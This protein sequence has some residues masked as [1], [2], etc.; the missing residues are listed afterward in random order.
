MGVPSSANEV[1]IVA[2]STHWDPNWLLKAAEYA[3]WLVRPTLDAVLDVLEDEPRRVFSLEC[4]FF[5]DRY[6]RQRPE[7]RQR[8]RELIDSNR[9]HF[10]GSGVTT[11]DTLLVDDE[12]LLRDLL[13]G[14]EWLREHGMDQQP[15]LL[16][17]PDSFGHSPGLPAILQS[18]GIER[19]AICRIA[20]MRFPGADLESASRFPRPG[21]AADELTAAGT[22]DFVWRSADGSEVLAHWTAHG[23]GHGDMI[24]SRGLSRALRLPLSFPDR[25]AVHVDRRIEKYLKDLRKLSL[26]PYRL[27]VLGY[28]FATPVPRLVELL[29]DWNARNHGRSGTFLVNGSIDDYLDLIDCHRGVLPTLELDP[30]PYWSGFYAS[31]TNIKTASRELGRRLIAREACRSQTP[32][33]ADD[34]SAWWTAVTSNHHDFI[35]G[36]S[37]DRVAEGEQMA[38][39][40][41]AL[42]DAPWPVVLRSDGSRRDCDDDSTTR[43]GSPEGD[44]GPGDGRP[45][46]DAGAGGRLEVEY[47]GHRLTVRAPWGSVTFDEQLGGAAV[48]VTDAHGRALA[49]RPSLEVAS[50]RDS[51]G[52]WRLGQEIN[53]GKWQLLDRSSRHPATIGVTTHGDG[54]RAEVRVAARCDE[55]DVVIEHRLCSMD[56]TVVS[57]VSV[58]PR[59]R[60]TFTLLIRSRSTVDSIVMHQPGGLVRRPLQ[61]FYRP[62]FWPL[63]SFVLTDPSGRSTSPG[64]ESE[65]SIVGVATA[66]PTG[67]H[68]G[69]DG[70]VELLAARSPFKE[71][72]FGFVPVMAPAWGWHTRLQS[73]TFAWTLHS[74][75]EEC[76]MLQ[77]VRLGRAL[78]RAAVDAAG[79]ASPDWP[80]RVADP[81]VEVIAVKPA[82]RGDGLIIRVRDWSAVVGEPRARSDRRVAL[83]WADPSSQIVAAWHTDALERDIDELVVS[84]GVVRVEPG[85]HLTTVRVLTAP[86]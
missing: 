41:A 44:A 23:Y 10:T 61:R 80:V 84:A 58:H 20:G 49:S 51:G 37:P 79:M 73:S 74:G 50:Y 68:V 19:V 21:T 64:A 65:Q 85:G 11:P 15:R 60:R 38:W 83:R 43:V 14:Q 6:W 52:L 59:R 39:L 5:V 55:H 29:D 47:G 8:L 1:V 66:V 13:L 70:T 46:F 22:S 67:V 33:A 69:E 76:D 72:A 56:P 28:D 81:D 48:E 63:H 16:Y 27:L 3:R 24:A 53:G 2:E 62:T 86:T 9:I 36:T 30:N 77:G 12:L 42:R 54:A 4:L 35:T 25:S 17:L 75:G 71:V 26:T 32:D 18:A 78:S 45:A 31:R 7:N 34:R 82:H 40:T 57:R